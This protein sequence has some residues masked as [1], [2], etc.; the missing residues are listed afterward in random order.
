MLPLGL[1]L[2]FKHRP[3]AS[4]V[5]IRFADQTLHIHEFLLD[6][7]PTLRDLIS[8]EKEIDMSSMS[9]AAGH[10]LLTYLYKG[11]FDLAVQYGSKDSI[12][13]GALR[14]SFEVYAAAKKYQLGPLCETMQASIDEMTAT[15]DSPKALMVF[16]E[17]C[18]YPDARDGWLRDYTKSLLNET[19][20]DVA[21]FLASDIMAEENAECIVS[22]TEMLL[23]SMI[24]SVREKEVKAKQE[25]EDREVADKLKTDLLG[26]REALDEKRARKGKLSKTDRA[27]YEAI[28]IQLAS[29]M[30]A[31]E[32]ELAGIESQPSLV[33]R[34]AGPEPEPGPADSAS[35]FSPGTGPFHPLLADPCSRLSS[36]PLA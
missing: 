6:A 7:S 11:H 34:D 18:P 17:A 24:R 26:E 16:K 12:E 22:A 33:A 14:R 35:A 5:A 1:Q 27:R 25:A 4:I 31:G 19:Y 15:L 10:I 29:M 28:T 23:R 36:I 13:T 8:P 2:T 20:P 3:F 30:S 9:G 21:T 32:L